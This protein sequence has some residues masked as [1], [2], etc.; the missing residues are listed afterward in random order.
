MGYRPSPFEKKHPG[1]VPW[2]HKSRRWAKSALRSRSGPRDVPRQ[3]RGRRERSGQS[4]NI[5][6]VRR[7]AWRGRMFRR[8]RR[9]RADFTTHCSILVSFVNGYLADGKV[10]GKLVVQVAE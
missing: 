3:G 2:H 9:D 5:E 10:E 6:R 4:V 8:A 1:R 7:T